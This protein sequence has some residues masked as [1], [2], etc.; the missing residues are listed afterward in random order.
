MLILFPFQKFVIK[1]LNCMFFLFTCYQFMGFSGTLYCNTDKRSNH[2]IIQKWL[3]KINISDI[4]QRETERLL[5]FK[6]YIFLSLRHKFGT[7]LFLIWTYFRI[8]IRSMCRPL[9]N[10]QNV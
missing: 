5:K 8:S 7:N 4:I 2:I 9:I 3:S 10:P 6:N 1:Y